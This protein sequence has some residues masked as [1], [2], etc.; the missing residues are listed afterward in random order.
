MLRFLPCLLILAACVD[1][2][3]DRVEIAPDSA[4]GEIAFELAGP[5]G[6]ALLVPVHLNGEGPFQFVLDTGATVTC[7]DDALASR[8]ELPDVRGVIGT[9]AGVG[10]EGGVRLV[11]V[12]SL[13]IGGVNAHDLQACVVDLEH[14]SGMGLELDGLIGLNVL[15][16]FRVTIDF[17]RRIVTLGQP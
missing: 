11:S 9:A 8:L 10:G 5:G 7:I 2:A 16:E 14:L 3:P 17:E 13:R 1:T 4:A 15:Q 12:D 6:A